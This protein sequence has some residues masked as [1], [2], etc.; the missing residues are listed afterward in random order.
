MKLKTLLFALLFNYTLVVF[1]Q[2]PVKLSSGQ[3]AFIEGPVWDRSDKIYFSDIIDRKVYTYSVTNNTF[4]VAFNIVSPA[5]TNGLM[6]DSNLNLIV[7]EF[8]DG[9]ITRR[10]TSG[11][12]LS[13]Y[14][15]GIL[16]ANDLCLD[17][18]EGIYASSP[19]SGKVYYISPDPSRT[20]TAIDETISSP[21]GVLVSTDG[22]KLFVNDSDGYT[23]YKYDINTTTGLV[24]NRVAFATLTDHDNTEVKSLADGMAIDKNGNLYVTAKKSIQVFNA[25]GTLTNTFNF[26]ENPTNC[27][28][29]GAGLGTLYVTTPKDLYK[30]VLT[31]VT[32]F[33]HPFDLPI[34]NL[35]VNDLDKVSFKMFP[36][37][38]TNHE[39]NVIVGDAK[40]SEVLLYN[41]FGQ[42]VDTC[43]F[44]RTNKAIQIKFNPSLKNNVYIL[45]IK[46]SEGSII[47]EKVILQ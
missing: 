15:T 14:A 12:I 18:K 27:T 26:T 30:I 6:F 28:F 44:K 36:N 13:T 19:N 31:D 1:S 11:T 22:K 16:N 4:A 47:N 41:N 20:L 24:S 34:A 38:I 5:R 39:I 9:L 23:I 45:S 21:N 2:N 43:N 37:P 35:S 29:G 25:L 32:G 40:I 10:N 33:Q 46:T 3:F 42:K 8:G 7:C 17:K